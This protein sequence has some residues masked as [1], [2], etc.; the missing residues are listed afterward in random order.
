M[1][2][3][4]VG[5]I[6]IIWNNAGILLIRTKGTNVSEILIEIYKFSFKK[7]HLKMSFCLG[8]NVLRYGYFTGN[9]T[10]IQVPAIASVPMKQPSM[11]SDFTLFSLDLWYS[12]VIRNRLH[13]SWDILNKLMTI[14][15]VYVVL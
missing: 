8:L 13:I 7:V 14:V 3:H 2:C 12:K 6:A 15:G 4:Q 10:V 5:T 1:A 9:E 11:I